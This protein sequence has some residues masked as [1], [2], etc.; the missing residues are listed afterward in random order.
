MAYAH[1]ATD[2]PRQWVAIATVNPGGYLN[3]PT[4]ERR[5]WHVAVNRYD[6]DAF[7]ADKNQLYAEALQCE[8]NENLWLDT[9]ALVAAH[10]AV[11]A[12]AKEPNELIDLLT[13][14]QGEVWH[15]SG[16][17]EERVSTGDIRLKLGMTSADAVRSHTIGRRIFEAMSSLGWT[18]APDTLRCHKHEGPTTGYSRPL[19][20]GPTGTPLAQS[21]ASAAPGITGLLRPQ[22][23]QARRVWWARV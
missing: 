5:Y 16:V 15:I 13:D 7:I 10:D 9:P 23:C 20:G 3:D 12:T 19:V 11:V 14:L 22:V 17:T 4:G 18:K 8:P 6:R 21:A 1:Y 2:V